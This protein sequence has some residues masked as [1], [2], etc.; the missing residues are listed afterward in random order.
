MS[1]ELIRTSGVAIL[2]HVK[3]YQLIYFLAAVG[4]LSALAMGLFSWDIPMFLGM[5]IGFLG[6]FSEINHAYAKRL[7]KIASV[8]R[9]HKEFL[10]EL[11]RSAF[12]KIIIVIQ[13]V[14]HFDRL[15]EIPSLV[16][17]PAPSVLLSFRS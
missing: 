5:I 8:I 11:L 17:K 3:G 13:S 16:A 15:M 7:R 12:S 10:T 14:R 4:A 2:H 9:L 1:R 6:C